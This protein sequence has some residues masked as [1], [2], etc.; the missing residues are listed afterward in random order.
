[1]NSSALIQETYN[2]FK[3]SH[4]FAQGFPI[5]C[6]RKRGLCLLHFVHVGQMPLLKGWD[7]GTPLR[8]HVG[9][10][11]AVS[12]ADNLQWA[13]KVLYKLGSNAGKSRSV[14]CPL[15]LPTPTSSLKTEESVPAVSGHHV[16]KYLIYPHLAP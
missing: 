3:C 1:M 13:L 12:K 15:T 11:S 14:T 5:N 16:Y 7:S 10:S 2:V 9:I 8:S 6:K 4:S